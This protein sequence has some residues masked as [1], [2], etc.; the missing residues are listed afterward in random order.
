MTDSFLRYSRSWTPSGI[1]TSYYFLHLLYSDFS[2][3]TGLVRPRTF[4]L[5]LTRK[6]GFMLPSGTSEI[7]SGTDYLERKNLPEKPTSCL[8]LNNI[9]HVLRYGDSSQ[10]SENIRSTFYY[11]WIYSHEPFRVFFSSLTL[12]I[13]LVWTENFNLYF[14]LLPLT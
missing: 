9:F 2:L 1:R 10:S 4:G 12:C 6:V 8:L 14:L 3:I 13:Q 5:N 7:T 11:H